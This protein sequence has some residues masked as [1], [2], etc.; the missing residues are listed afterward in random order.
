VALN[1]WEHL[2]DDV[3]ALKSVSGLLRPGGAVV[4]VAP[5]FE[6]AMSRFDR[7]IG[8]VRRYTTKSMRA[9]VISAGLEVEELRYINPVGLISWLI[10]CR[11]LRQRPRNGAALRAY[12]RLLVPRLRRAEKDRRPPF[13]QSVFVVARKPD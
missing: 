11:M 1:V 10:V 4:L 3:I 13:G 9:A 7:E 12:D 8:H 6:F 5:A 2:D